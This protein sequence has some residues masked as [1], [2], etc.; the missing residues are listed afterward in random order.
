MPSL[1]SLELSFDDRNPLT[2]YDE[3][4]YNPASELPNTCA[5]KSPIQRATSKK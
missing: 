5:P 3:T 2:Y 1:P 4:Y